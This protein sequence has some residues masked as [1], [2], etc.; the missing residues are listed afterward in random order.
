[1]FFIADDLFEILCIIA[2]LRFVAISDRKIDR[3][4]RFV[5]ILDRKLDLN[6]RFVA[7]LNVDEAGSVLHARPQ[8]DARPEDMQ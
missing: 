4:L 2:I 5:A 1:M 8:T 7:I 3:N 6:L